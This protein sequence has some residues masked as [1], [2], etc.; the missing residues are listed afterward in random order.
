MRP[1][2]SATVMRPEY[3]RGGFRPHAPRPRAVRTTRPDVRPLRA[4]AL[5]R[6]GPA[7]ALVPRLA[8][9]GRRA[10]GARRRGRNGCGGDRVGAREPGPDCGRRRPEPRDARRRTRAGRG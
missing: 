6:P 5:V 8:D 9:P 3:G 7:L 2:S 10:P 4:P 1:T